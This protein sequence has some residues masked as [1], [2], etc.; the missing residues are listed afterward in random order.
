M[1][2][3]YSG[4]FGMEMVIF[5]SWLFNDSAS[6]YLF[7]FICGLIM[8]GGGLEYPHPRLAIRGWLR[9]GN[10]VPRG[11]SGHPVTGDWMQGL[12]P[13]AVKHLL[14]RNPKK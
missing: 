1:V 11:I 13:C 3:H 2:Y 5:L 4:F 9:K 6:R 12:R 7:V 10:P 8:C 14:L